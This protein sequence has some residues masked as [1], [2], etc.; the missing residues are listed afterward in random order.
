MAANNTLLLRV[1]EKVKLYGDVDLLLQINKDNMEMDNL[2][3]N[4][5]CEEKQELKME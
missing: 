4:I 5:C 2:L 1:G 3:N